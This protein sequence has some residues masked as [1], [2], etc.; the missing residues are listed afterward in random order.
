MA[1]TQVSTNPEV[2][3]NASNAS[4][5][6]TKST[7]NLVTILYVIFNLSSDAHIYIPK[8]TIVAHPDSNKPEVDIIEVVETIQEAPETMQ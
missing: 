7:K 5:F 6:P 4:L 3:S 8:G 1:G 2:S